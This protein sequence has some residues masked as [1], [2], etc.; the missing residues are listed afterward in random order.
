M[1]QNEH[2]TFV[3]GDFVA[4][5]LG[6]KKIA[7]GVVFEVIENSRT[8]Q[9]SGRTYLVRSKSGQLLGP[10]FGKALR[11]QSALEHE[12]ESKVDFSGARSD[13][14]QQRRRRRNGDGDGGGG[15]GNSADEARPPARISISR[16]RVAPR[17]EDDGAASESSDWL[18][19]DNPALRV[20][21]RTHGYRGCGAA[22]AGSQH[23]RQS[24]SEPGNSAQSARAARRARGAST[25]SDLSVT[26]RKL[27]LRQ[28]LRQQRQGQVKPWHGATRSQLNQSTAPRDA[29]V[30]NTI[31]AEEQTRLVD[32]YL[33][34]RGQR[35]SRI[36]R[37]NNEP[38]ETVAAAVNRDGPR[39]APYLVSSRRTNRGSRTQFSSSRTRPQS[40]AGRRRLEPRE[41]PKQSVMLE[42]DF[43]KGAD[44]F[45]VKET[46]K[47]LTKVVGAANPLIF[48]AVF[49][50]R[51]TTH[52]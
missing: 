38:T 43:S 40:S 20:A 36:H 4:V 23:R 1:S 8:S 28:Q 7:S 12:S 25:E 2:S 6:R 9:Q 5:F 3:P 33:N 35:S 37:T 42:F 27:M 49:V 11:R 48:I 47:D 39:R 30:D 45:K 18:A 29:F 32:A 10:F 34:R 17:R 31:S 44:R 22:A 13:V 26:E 21:E 50:V 14:R 51:R 24:S 15:V 52:L 46:V 16:P 41:L 19:R